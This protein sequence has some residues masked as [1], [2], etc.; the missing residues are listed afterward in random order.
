MT[1]NQ[2]QSWISK[3][4]PRVE[5]GRLLQGRGKFID[6]IKL[7]RLLVAAFVRSPVAHAILKKIN[8]D[9]AR[10]L[11][12]VHAC[13]CLRR[14]T[15]APYARTGSACSCHPVQ[16]DLRLIRRSSRMKRSATSA[17]QLRSIAES[18]AIAEDGVALVELE[19]ESLPVIL[20]PRDGIDKGAQ[21]ARRDCPDNLV[22]R[23]VL[24]YGNGEAGIRQCGA[25]RQRL[26]LPQ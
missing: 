14:L 10:V 7:D 13:A 15:L 8:L 4:V 22:A 16:S 23:H 19:F 18:R 5:D 3:S 1:D 21:K 26:L 25:S 12:G 9:A 24:K 20:N 17:N 11:P 6:D 2:F